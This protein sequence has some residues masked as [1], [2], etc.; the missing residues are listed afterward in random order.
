MY[1]L[2]AHAAERVDHSTGI[3]HQAPRSIAEQAAA[4]EKANRAS[5]VNKCYKPTLTLETESYTHSTH[6][7][8]LQTSNND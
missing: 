5:T 8:L 6:N 2:L 3:D 1:V 7:Q 4:R